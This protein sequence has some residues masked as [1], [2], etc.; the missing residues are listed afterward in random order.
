MNKYNRNNTIIVIGVAILLL[1]V[2]ALIYNLYFKNYVDNNKEEEKKESLYVDIT[3]ENI[4]NELLNTINVNNLKGVASF[5]KNIDN[6]NAL[7]PLEKIDIAYNA[8][9]KEDQSVIGV[10]ELDNY[11]KDAFKTTIYYDKSD[12]FCSNGEVLYQF[13]LA[14]NS[15]VYN[16]LH[17]CENHNEVIPSYTKVLSAK[18]K[19]NIYVITVSYVWN[20]TLAPDTMYETYNNALN[21]KDMLLAVPSEEGN[22]SEEDVKNFIDSSYDNIKDKLHKYTYV[23]DKQNDKYL[24]ESVKYE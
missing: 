21:Q 16:S 11:F 13:D 7:Q 24:L 17:N 3:D 1:L 18:K 9:K 6:I 22:P 12:I 5:E 10:E 14:T 8:I 2:S 15:Y 20:N 4:I 19:N 23:F